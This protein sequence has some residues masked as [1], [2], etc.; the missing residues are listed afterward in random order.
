M[1]QNRSLFY[2]LLWLFRA[3]IIISC[4]AI[5]G[6]YMIMPLMKKQFVDHGK[7]FTFDELI[8]MYAISQSAPG[9]IAINLSAITGYRVAGILGAVLSSVAAVLPPLIIISVV[10]TCY[11]QL[12]DNHEVNAALKG[13]MAAIAAI[14]IDVVIEMGKNVARTKEPLGLVTVA[15][16]FFA[17]F[18]F[19]INAILLIISALLFYT[20]ILNFQARRKK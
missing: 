9:A 13:M 3:N 2:R 8:E 11:H 17:A 6:G 16:I 10:A 20:I 1:L 19:D 14:I 18:V 5:G 15:F 4:M 12:I 7:I